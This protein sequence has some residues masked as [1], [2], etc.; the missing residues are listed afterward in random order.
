MVNFIGIELLGTLKSES[1]FEQN[2][3][4]IVKYWHPARLFAQDTNQ[5]FQLNQEYVSELYDHDRWHT[6]FET[7]EN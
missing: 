5:A 2:K 7:M 4:N 1:A 6:A 3:H